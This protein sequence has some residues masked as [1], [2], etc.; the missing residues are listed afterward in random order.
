MVFTPSIA[1]PS[2][3]GQV[4]EFSILNLRA[5]ALVA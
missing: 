3:I 4:D 1:D 2:H 5:E